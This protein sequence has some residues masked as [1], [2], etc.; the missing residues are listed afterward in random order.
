MKGR[1]GGMLPQM[2]LSLCD[3]DLQK[4]WAKFGYKPSLKVVF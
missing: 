1:Q 2:F 3:D 4:E